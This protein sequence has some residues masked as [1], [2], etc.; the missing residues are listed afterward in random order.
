[1]AI[2]GMAGRFPAAQDLRTFWDNLRAGK[3]AF[4]RVPEG[5]WSDGEL[6]AF[7]VTPIEE[8]RLRLG[9]FLEGAE[10]F[11]AEHFGIS[12]REAH[13]M[14]PQQRLLL[15]ECWNALADAGFPHQRGD[16]R[17]GVF[18]GASGGEYAQKC[19]LAGV[20]ADGFSLAAHLPST[21]AARISYQ[22]DL[23]GPALVLDLGCASSVAALQAGVE[24]LRRG[25]CDVA[26]VAAVAV[27]A[28][29]QIPVMAERAG[30]LS[31]S[32]DCRP[33][34]ADADGMLLGEAAVAVVLERADVAFARGDSVMAIVKEVGIAQ[35][36]TTNG[37]SAPSAT[38][39]ASL[40]R[41]VLERA[42]IDPVT[43]D[44]VEGHGVGTPAGDGAELRALEESLVGA[45]ALPIGSVKGNTGHTLAAAGLTALAKVVLQMAHGELVPVAGAIEENGE[46]ERSSLELVR[47]PAPWLR[48]ADRPRR[49]AI[50]AF[51]INGGNGFIVVE[52]P[53]A[54]VSPPS[55]GTSVER[56]FLVSARTEE[57]LHRRLEALGAWIGAAKPALR[58]LAATLVLGHE[59]MPWRAAIIAAT[60]AE[61]EQAI[62]GCRET[63]GSGERHLLGEGRPASRATAG[64]F[65]RVTADLAERLREA[66]GGDGRRERLTALAELFVQGHA[67]PAALAEGGQPAAWPA[68]LSVRASAL[69][70]RGRGAGGSDGRKS[71]CGGAS[72]QSPRA[73]GAADAGPAAARRAGRRCVARQA[74]RARAR[75]RSSPWSFA[76]GSSHELGLDVPLATLVGA[77]GG[78][79]PCGAAAK[80]RGSSSEHRLGSAGA[81]CPEP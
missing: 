15:E 11:D 17:I 33:F 52:E 46:A 22:F 45:S 47:R 44:Y 13:G 68:R 58:D 67:M 39:Q 50:N 8:G 18:V 30:I 35:A 70:D 62:A 6:R 25:E 73:A 23:R 51:A 79:A 63:R 77:R 57:G 7:G 75:S 76:T 61:L 66:G 21:L 19:A 1:M 55:L 38:A 5:R 60:A 28:T 41:G 14:D 80:S 54:L 56:L 49:A 20:P 48:N 32:G 31:S 34:A 74:A 36:G 65:A 16:R 72:P 71:R 37:L 9:G 59:D 78:A 3:R 43:I 40:Q 24:S 81:R 26:L 64:V 2:V 69:L 12:P 29:P 4:A 27:M 42:R 10:L 53:A